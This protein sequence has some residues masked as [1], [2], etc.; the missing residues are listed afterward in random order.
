MA[1][2]APDP[3]PALSALPLVDPPVHER[4]LALLPLPVLV[5]RAPGQ[6]VYANA[7]WTAFTTLDL[8]GTLG[9]AWAQAVDPRDVELAGTAFQTMSTADAQAIDVR[10]IVGGRSRW[11]RWWSTASSGDE[12]IVCI[13]DI[14]ADKVREAA[15]FRR[16]THDPLTGLVNRTQFLAALRRA[17]AA[18]VAS[19]LSP[20]VMFIDLDGFKA[21]NDAWGHSVGD[22]VLAVVSERLRDA[23]RPSDVVARVGGDEFAILCC[24]TMSTTEVG[25]V[26]GRVLAAI[27]QPVNVGV[28]CTIDAAVGLARPGPQ[29]EEPEA[30]LAR[31]DAA[32][33]A[34]KRRHRPEIGAAFT[35]RSSPR[36]DRL[37]EANDAMQ[38]AFRVV[39]ELRTGKPS[40][41]DVG[42]TVEVIDGLVAAL[43]RCA[44]ERSTPWSGPFGGAYDGAPRSGRAAPEPY[45]RAGDPSGASSARSGT[46]RP[47][48]GA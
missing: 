14:D 26:V 44:F 6:V 13:A 25:A 9:R 20:A 3:N 17:L 1:S 41:G 15:L 46:N 24:G 38:E 28:T 30:I 27:R 32:M 12:V 33:Y 39:L 8:D 47:A 45:E 21:V 36:R 43:R 48:P 40:N 42:R 2:I 23:V 16:A 5:S 37:T 18:P 11:T 22:R 19:G 31:A 35:T 10:M 34:A 4:L 7:A 29:A